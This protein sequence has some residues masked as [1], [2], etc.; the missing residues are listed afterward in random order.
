M[1]TTK[2]DDHEFTFLIT[3]G[4]MPFGRITH[5]YEQ[6]EDGCSFYAE[7]E[8]GCRVPIVG[9]LIN[10]L[11]LPFVYNKKTAW[12]WIAHNVEETGRTEDVLPV[13]YAKYAKEDN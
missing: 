7:T 6:E 11:L 1:H 9:W 12:N 4:G 3:A 5:L 2:L 10:W 13:L 8:M